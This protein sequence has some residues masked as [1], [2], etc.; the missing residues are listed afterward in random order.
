MSRECEDR[1]RP[2]MLPKH[3]ARPEPYS[4]CHELESNQQREDLQSP[5]LPLELPWRGTPNGI[6]TRVLGLKAQESCH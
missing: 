2:Q 1:T 4:R 6:R 5:A 3:P